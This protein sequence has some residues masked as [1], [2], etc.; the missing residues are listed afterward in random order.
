VLQTL[1]ALL[2]WNVTVEFSTH[3][4]DVENIEA[5]AERPAHVRVTIEPSQKHHHPDWPG[6]TRAVEV[7][8]VIGCDGVKS[9]TRACIGSHDLDGATG[10]TQRYTGTYAYRGLLDAEE[11]RKVVGESVMTATMW[12]AKDKVS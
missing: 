2:P 5:T 4:S 11:A 3:I 6:T 10:K 12:C 9:V 7:D 8:A 1:V